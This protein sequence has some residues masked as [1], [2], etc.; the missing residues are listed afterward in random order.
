MGMIRIE[1]IQV[2]YYFRSL[3]TRHEERHPRWSL[4][5]LGKLPSGICIHISFVIIS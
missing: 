5:I 1:A 2:L 3:K 4:D